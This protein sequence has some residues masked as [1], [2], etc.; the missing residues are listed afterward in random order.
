MKPTNIYA[1]ID[2]RTGCIRYVG[3]T[4]STIER[5]LST[6]ISYAKK[7]VHTK[8][9]RW[10]KGLID[11]GLRPDTMLLAVANDDWAE[12]ERHWIAK[13]RYD[14]LDLLNHT[15]GGEGMNEYSHTPE[16]RA[17]MSEAQKLRFSIKPS[18]LKGRSR[19]P[20]VRQKCSESQR[21]RTISADHRAKISAALI[22]RKIPQE[23]VDKIS[24]ANRGKKLPPRSTEHS[25]KHAAALRGIPHSEE[26]KSK[27]SASLKGIPKSD[28]HRRKLSEA[29]FLR[30]QAGRVN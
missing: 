5:R 2:P 15:A 28:D 10:I 30:Y 19:P 6:H 9:A 25:E 16:S 20:E 29:A 14:G 3:K 24:A 26:H 8:C 12:V 22:G 11:A 17:R 23:I 18:Q 7:G 13:F 1:L 21:G 4:I 27:I